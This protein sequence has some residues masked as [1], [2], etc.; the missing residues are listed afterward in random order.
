LITQITKIGGTVQINKMKEKD[1]LTE[2]IIGSCFKVHT[3]LGPGFNEKIYHNAL[4]IAFKEQGLEYEIEKEYEV[5][6][7]DKRVG[8]FR[9]DLIV[10]GKVIVEIK[11]ATGK[12]PAIFE[13]QILSYL[14]ASGIKVGLLVNFGNKSCQVKRFVFQSAQPKISVKS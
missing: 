7:K 13:S 9:A 2:R 14:K 6:Y 3:E 8:K 1:I 4:I 12:M 10:D 11:S 5:F